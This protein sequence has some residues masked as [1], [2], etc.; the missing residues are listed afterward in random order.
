MFSRQVARFGLVCAIVAGCGSDGLRPGGGG[1]T[2][3]GA[4]AT[5]A[6]GSA[7]T[8]GD[9]AG[10]TGGTAGTSGTTGG[11]AGTSGATAG[12]SGSAAGAS[13]STAGTA[14]ATGS[15]AG[16]SGSTAGTTGGTAGASGGTAGMTGS[17]GR[18]SGPSAG[19]KKEP[20]QE[21]IG[22]GVIHNIGITGLA[23]QYVA[24][25]AQRTYCTTM[26]K[27]YDPTTPYPVVIYGP[28]CGGQSCEGGPFT[29][30]TDILL[31][32]ATKAPAVYD[33]KVPPVP[34]AAA[35]GCFQTGVISTVDSPELPYFDQVLAEVASNYCV[36]LGRVFVAGSSSGAWFSN[37]LACARGNVI[38][39][40][41]ADS[42]GIPVDRPA[43]TGGAGVAE[44][45]GDS[46][47]K[48]D[49]MGRE[50]GAAL[51]RDL[52]I[53]T[54]GCNTTPT[55]MKFGNATCDVYSG[56]SSPVAWCNVG[57]GHQSGL[58]SLSPVGWAFWS[59]L[60]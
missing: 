24:G 55:P 32:Q 2:S 10:A 53:K 31:V 23:Q 11:T 38:R 8:T 15:T 48:K 3:G 27:N 46:A 33:G 12:T 44:F 41:A 36:D 1:G 49:S 51:A 35:P 54:N 26:P 7:S 43:C 13:G 30:R 20:P 34:P 37:Y 40:A 52:F 9:A 60:K 28:G 22:S 29:G 18:P 21:P 14:G 45:P 17:T 6:A 47:T 59:S 25:Y 42:G 58:G 56:C 57:G 4:G 39:G 5:G 16:A 19:C 50:I